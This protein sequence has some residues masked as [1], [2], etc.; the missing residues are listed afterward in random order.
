MGEGGKE[1]ISQ[2]CGFILSDPRDC[3]TLGDDEIESSWTTG[4]G[5]RSSFTP[6]Y[7]FFMDCVTV[8]HDCTSDVLSRMFRMRGPALVTNGDACGRF[9]YALTVRKNSITMNPS[10]Q[11]RG[12]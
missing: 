8:K 12:S 1:A 11:C 4:Q 2:I 6:F 9:C 10:S 3:F 7:V 5:R